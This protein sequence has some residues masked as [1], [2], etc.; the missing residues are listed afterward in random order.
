M[1]VEH[2]KILV[3]SGSLTLAFVKQKVL[4]TNFK[5]STERFEIEWTTYMAVRG[6][7]EER[8]ERWKEKP[9]S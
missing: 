9:S 5:E 3:L 4:V 2:F 6:P 7:G 8:K 1:E